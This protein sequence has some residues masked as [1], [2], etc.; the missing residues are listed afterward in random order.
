MHDS[1]GGCDASGG[2][3]RAGPLDVGVLAD[4]AERGPMAGEVAALYGLHVCE[5]G[6]ARTHAV[7]QAH[8]GLGLRGASAQ[9]A[10]A[11]L[12]GL[13]MGRGRVVPSVAMNYAGVSCRQLAAEHPRSLCE[14]P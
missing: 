8:R 1:Y 3:G 11:T 14:Y 5:T 12:R 7:V 10:R 13:A 2:L 4:M 6:R 9:A